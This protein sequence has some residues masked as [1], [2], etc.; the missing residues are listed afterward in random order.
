MTPTEPAAPGSRVDPSGQRAALRRALETFYAARQAC[1]VA[2]FTGFFAPDARLFVL[3]NPVLNPGSGMRLGRAGIGHHL[4]QLHAANVYLDSTIVDVVAEGDSI[5]VWWR[6][7]IRR[8][9]DEAETTLDIL[10][11]MRVRNGQIVELAQ[12][13]DTGTAA[14]MREPLLRP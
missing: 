5:A 8:R 1:D 12:F 2:A 9:G 13:F 11:Q 4:S 7:R 10:D 6:A 14:L 3:G